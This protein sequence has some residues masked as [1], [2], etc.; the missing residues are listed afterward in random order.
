MFVVC[1]DGT[2]CAILLMRLAG[3]SIVRWGGSAP[4]PA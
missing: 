4:A 3:G 2:E 1:I